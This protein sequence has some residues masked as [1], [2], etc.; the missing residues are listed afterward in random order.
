VAPGQ[1]LADFHIFRLLADAWG[2]GDMFA[3]WDSPQAVFRILQRLSAG[4]PCDIS[5]I[6]GYAMLDALG[7]VQWPFPAGATWSDGDGERR[8]FADGRFCHPDGR[9]RFRWG[10]PRPPA[11]ATSRR[12]PMV[13]LTGRGSAAQWHTQTRTAKSPILRAL[14]PGEAYAELNPADAGRIGVGSGMRVAIRSARGQVVVRAFV[15]PTIPPGNVFLSMH[16]PGTNLLTQPSFDPSSRQPSYKY[17]AVDVAR[18][19]AWEQ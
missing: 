8:L 7:G 1:A 17:C 11:E 10:D 16:W 2:C 14:A 9:A 3:E 12:Y 4:R 13:L 18:P 15:T 6:E 5:G 19:E